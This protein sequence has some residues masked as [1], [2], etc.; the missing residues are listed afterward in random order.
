MLLLKTDTTVRDRG[1]GRPWGDHEMKRTGVQQTEGEG[2]TE[3]RVRPSILSVFILKLVFFFFL[4]QV[5]SV[6]LHP[7]ILSLP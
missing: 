4:Q 5:P 7:F 3:E 6:P 2:E 1:R